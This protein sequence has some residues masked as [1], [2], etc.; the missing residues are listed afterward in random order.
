[1]EWLRSLWPLKCSWTY[2]ENGLLL[3]RLVKLC[4]EK[5]RPPAFLISLTSSWHP[6]G[7]CPDDSMVSIITKMTHRSL[8]RIILRVLAHHY[9]VT[10]HC[11]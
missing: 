2:L 1:M 11:H 7:S 6:G 3:P 8:S 5:D 9:V 4:L 10:E